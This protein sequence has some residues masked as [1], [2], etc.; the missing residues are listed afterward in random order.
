MTP[1]LTPTLSVVTAVFLSVSLAAC[2][3]PVGVTTPDL[4]GLEQTVQA[5][6]R[7]T[8]A[9][10]SPATEAPPGDAPATDPP[11][12][13]TSTFT[14][15]FTPSPSATPTVTWTPIPCNRA[16]FV[17]DVTVPDGT[18]FLPN[19]HFNKTWRLR[20]VGTCT[21]TS[22]YSIVFD[23]GDRMG[24]PDSAQLTG[25]TIPPGGTLDV[26]VGLEAPGSAG[27][28]KGY[29]KVRDPGG[30]IF[31]VGASGNVPFFVDI[32]VVPAA[33]SGPDFS[34]AFEN[35]HNCAAGPYATF[36]VGNTGST[37]FESIWLRIVDT[38]TSG[39][40]YPGGSNNSPFLGTSNEC[41][42]KNSSMGPGSVYFIAAF[43][44]ASPPHGHHAKLTLKMCTAD[45]Q[46][47]TCLT[48]ELDFVIP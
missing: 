26:S 47:G 2:N 5:Q 48:K 6:V 20:N 17:T 30:V 19:A 21:W 45:N 24:G 29:W 31:G 25:G 41:P 7:M 9:V 32:E 14:P 23:H 46:A 3:L 8:S 16:E 1:R 10:L 37:G 44:G 38:D 4:S 34:L 33:P 28:Y 43:I 39:A 40:L 18:D 35:L 11:P 27:A 13:P 22:E 15:T 12:T 36:R 42:P